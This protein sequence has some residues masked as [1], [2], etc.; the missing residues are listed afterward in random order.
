MYKLSVLICSVFGEREKEY[1]LLLSELKHQIAGRDVEILRCIDDRSHTI[2]AKRQ[3]LLNIAK[4]EYIVFIDDD[5]WVAPNYIEQ[6]L[7]AINDKPDS[8]G[9]Y[10]RCTINGEFAGFAQL[11]NDYE[12]WADNVGQFS[13]VRTPYHKTPMKRSI[14]LEAGFDTS[15]RFAEDHDFSKKLKTKGLIK[16]EAFIPEVLYFY[17]YNTSMPAA[18]KYG[19]DKQPVNPLDWPQYLITA[20]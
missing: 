14:A 12:E 13:W 8:I 3:K 7:T 16:T 4:G 6:I 9:F 2:G 18:E 17:R 15:L 1:A 20:E 5:D 11:S 19:I 10:Q